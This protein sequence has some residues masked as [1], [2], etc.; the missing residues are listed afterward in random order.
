MTQ[1][2]LS[3]IIAFLGTTAWSDADLKPLAGDASFRRYHRLTGG[4]KAAVLMDAPVETNEPVTAFLKIDAHLRAQGLSAPEIFATDEARGLVLL[5]DLGDH[6]FADVIMAQP[7]LEQELYHNAAEILCHLHSQPAPPNLAAYTPHLMGEMSAL[8]CQWYSPHV[9]DL[10]DTLSGQVQALAEILASTTAYRF[11]QRDYHAQNLLWL[12]NRSSLGRVGLLDFQ[13]AMMAPAAYDLVSLLSDAR[14]DVSPSTIAKTRAHY[15]ALAKEDAETFQFAYDVC[16]A[17]RSLRLLGL[18]PRL[19][20]RDGKPGY[21]PLLPRVWRDLQKH[22][23]HPELKD[24]RG[25]ITAHLPEPTHEVLHRI[26]ERKS[27]TA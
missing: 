8:A 23:A 27:V 7:A 4:P 15:I 10:T 26:Y 2:R 19:W 18:F 3:E 25:L 21:L 20:L 24:L 22:L 16:G 17:Q 9:K 12:P 5:E 13:D 1:Q 14:R 11:T 6:L